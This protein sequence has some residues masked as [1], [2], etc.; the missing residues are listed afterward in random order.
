MLF[1]LVI[2]AA[3][4]MLGPIAWSVGRAKVGL[5]RFVDTFA[6][7][8]IGGLAAFHILPEAIDQ[9][10]VRAVIAAVSGL[11]ALAAIERIP[12][13]TPDGLASSDTLGILAIAVHALLDGVG[14]AVSSGPFLALATIVHRLP[15][16]IVVWT[17]SRPERNPR[18]AMAFM[19]AIV[20]INVFGAT[21]GTW[22]APLLQSDAVV[23]LQAFAVGTLVHLLF[24]RTRAAVQTA[25]RS[26][27]R[28]AVVG[29]LLGGLAVG[30]VT[31]VTPDH[32]VRAAAG[33]FF[34]HVRLVLGAVFVAATARIV[35][36]GVRPLDRR[37]EARP[38]VANER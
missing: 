28:P 6:L 38:F 17:L 9:C 4:L 3:S 25:E 2:S 29:V 15:E 11:G 8:A 18:R 37:R 10:G 33:P 1:L 34:G 31:L 7:V 30:F 26:A 23:L 5:L 16:G 22:I 35:L 12:R 27:E 13:K 32:P 14:L 19:G 20:A 36:H 21:V 24:D